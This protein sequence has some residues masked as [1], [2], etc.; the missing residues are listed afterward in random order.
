MVFLHSMNL[1]IIALSLCHLSD[2]PYNTE[3]RKISLLSGVKGNGQI[4]C[5]YNSIYTFEFLQTETTDLSFLSSYKTHSRK[6]GPQ[7]ATSLI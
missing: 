2:I 4:L 3:I 1:K 7:K 6:Q 5:R